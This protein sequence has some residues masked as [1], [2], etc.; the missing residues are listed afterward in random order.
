MSRDRFLGIRYDEFARAMGVTLTPVQNYIARIAFDGDNPGLMR[1]RD[2]SQDEIRKVFGDIP[3]EPVD[4]DVRSVLVAVCGARGGKTYTLVAL[5]LLHLA[6]SLDLSALAPGEMASGPLVAPDMRLARQALR[7]VKGIVD[8]KLTEYLE[9]DN[10]DQVVLNVR[11][12]KV[13]IEALPASAGGKSLRG[14]SLIGAG[15]DE[16]AF[17][18]DSDSVINDEEIFKAVAPRIVPGGQVLIVSTPWS[19]SG[20]LYT[21]FEENWGRPTTALAVHAPTT[22]L[23]PDKRTTGMVAREKKRDPENHRREYMAEFMSTSGSQFFDTRTVDAAFERWEKE[24]PKEGYAALAT[25]TGADLGFTSDHS[26][27]AAVGEQ[28]GTY[29]SQDYEVHRPEKGK[30][31]KPSE[32]MSSLVA[33]AKRNYSDTVFGDVHYQDLVREHASNA[34]LSFVQA[35]AGAEGKLDQY[36]KVRALLAEGRVSLKPIDGLREQLLGVTKKPTPGGGM[37]ISQ[38]RSKTGGH[39]DLASALVLALWACNSVGS[40]RVLPDDKLPG[41]RDSDLDDNNDPDFEDGN[42][43]ATGSAYEL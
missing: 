20:L 41:W 27:F 16:F 32:V 3:D 2:P 12:R 28:D 5:R 11:G 29:R 40:G 17:F 34:G 4:P 38:K 39:S 10:A 1:H 24:R 31:L 9:E 33:F 35:P 19:E 6:M 43:G 7:Y 22:L 23:R 8:T 36:S 21:L 15:L 18:R 26:A 30:P 37:Q 13:A 25:T 14:R 42:V